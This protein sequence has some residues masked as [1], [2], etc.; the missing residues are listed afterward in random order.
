MKS[1]SLSN[2]APAE[3]LY[4]SAPQSKTQSMVPVM[5]GEPTD[6]EQAPVV[7]GK[8]G[9]RG[10]FAWVGDVNDEEETA[11]VV[12]KLCEWALIGILSFAFFLRIFRKMV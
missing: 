4:S 10:H 2:V 5:A 11:V 9:E 6:A 7:L 1:V 12:Q 3:R 8:V